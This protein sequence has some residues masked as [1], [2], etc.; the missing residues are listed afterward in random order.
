MEDTTRPIVWK[1]GGP[2][3]FGI[4][5]TGLLMSKLATRQGKN[6]FD[7][8]EYPSL[9][10]GGHNTYEVMMHSAT[11]QARCVPVDVLACLTPDTAELHKDRLHKKSLILHDEKDQVSVSTGTTV[12]VPITE[13]IADLKASKIMG[14]MVMFGAS[15][16]ILGSS[17]EAVTSCITAQFSSKGEE[18]VSQNTACALAGFDHITSTAQ[19]LC[20]TTLSDSPTTANNSDISPKA[21]LTGNDAFSLAAIAAK[22]TFYAAYPM[23]PS[24]SVLTTLAA[25]APKAGMIVRHAEDEIGVVSEALGASFAGARAAVG[26]S[27]GGF[28]L[29]TE[30]VSYAGVAEIPLVIFM[31]QRP[32]PATGMPTWTEQGDLLFTVHAGHGEF[33]KIVL[34][35]GTIQ[36]M[37]ELTQ[38]AF[39]LAD[40]YQ[41]PVILLS[42]KYLSES[43]Y[44]LPV[45]EVEKLCS[46]PQDRGETLSRPTTN[47]LRYAITDSGI[48][49]RLLPGAEGAFYQANSYE[50]S[51]DSHTSEEAE[52]RVAQVDKRAKKTE[53]YLAKHWL[54]PKVFGSLA[55]AKVTLVSWGSH[56]PVVETA[57]EM[58]AN[59]GMPV[60]HVHFSSV[61]PL[62]ADQIRPLFEGQT[63]VVVVE[64]NSTGQFAQLLQKETGISTEQPILKYDGRPFY[65]EE[66][67]AAVKERYAN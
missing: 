4:M 8:A 34:A 13:I 67:V 57:R 63:P 45:S 58:L 61:F 18:V 10:Q 56:Q 46:K 44:S 26:T 59:E 41:T 11:A 65:P 14:N 30:S 64:N 48:S 6:I 2:A 24:S 7:Y 15:A 53:T 36:E 54:P 25:F 50:H 52:A 32:G 17:K 55:D 19:A 38:H 37:I 3:G 43:H 12:S 60:A 5:T 62:A 20:L 16:A 35:P 27:G 66:I 33:P 23:T 42:D 51:E 9:V 40:I 29:M 22:C 49:P 31:S 28:A 1:I 21:L 47:Y 39:N